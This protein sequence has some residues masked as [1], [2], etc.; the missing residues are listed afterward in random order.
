MEQ[1]APTA[2]MRT[3]LVTDLVQARRNREAIE[4]VSNVDLAAECAAIE[5]AGV[6]AVAPIFPVESGRN[7]AATE[8]VPR[9]STPSLSPPPDTGAMC[10]TSPPVAEEEDEGPRPCPRDGNERT[11]K[12][13]TIKKP[14]ALGSAE[15]AADPS[16]YEARKQL[17]L[18]PSAAD[19]QILAPPLV[20]VD[21]FF[22][23]IVLL[24]RRVAA[25]LASAIFDGSQPA[26]PMQP[27]SAGHMTPEASGLAAAE[28]A[29]LLGPETC[30]RK[31]TPQALDEAAIAR[32]LLP[33]NIS[34]TTELDPS[35]PIGATVPTDMSAAEHH[36][37]PVVMA[38]PSEA[39]GS[40]AKFD[41]AAS[42]HNGET[43]ESARRPRPGYDALEFANE[44]NAVR[45]NETVAVENTEDTR[46]LEARENTRC[47]LEAA[48][49]KEAAFP[50]P[51]T[52]AYA[53]APSVDTK[54][55]DATKE[56]AVDEL[57]AVIESVLSE[58]WRR[59]PQCAPHRVR[60][61]TPM[62]G[63]SVATSDSLLEELKTTRQ[64]LH[65]QPGASSE[66]SKAVFIALGMFSLVGT[67]GY[68]LWHSRLPIGSFLRDLARIV[69]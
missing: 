57:G 24:P 36:A 45:I 30:A 6:V 7:A 25:T 19:A 14:V 64:E 53:C 46:A 50:A 62:G 28:T 43:A 66:S 22:G 9:P 2:K 33:I 29:I 51:S 39:V 31:A 49:S 47:E 18:G 8:P 55:D 16:R 67:A 27:Q 44:A 69:S 15:D 59:E 38:G 5:P 48:P 60:V 40:T 56:S 34:D 42:H 68:G 21:R 52:T 54:Q 23:R 17:S 12:E 37:Q 11:A 4:A 32:L 26:I 10:V 20:P 61:A 13:N 35:N 41:I 63:G 58:R 3:K 1:A 65:P